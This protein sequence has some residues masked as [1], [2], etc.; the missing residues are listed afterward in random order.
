MIILDN[1]DLFIKEKLQKDQL[2]SKKAEDVFDIFLK[3]DFKMEEKNEKKV[4]TKDKQVKIPIMKRLL[5]TAASLVIVFG[6]ANVYATTNGYG[7]VFFMIK[8]LVTGEKTVVT[9]KSEILSDRDISISYEP[10]R[11]TENIRMQI[12]N[13]QVKDN[14]AKLIIAINEAKEEDSSIV[15]LKYKVYNSAN[16]LLCEQKS[17]KD[18]NNIEY[19]EELILDKFK[20]EDKILILEVNKA[21]NN[22]IAKITIDLQSRNITVE[23]EAEALKKV[24]EIELKKYLGVISE[25]NGEPKGDEGKIRFAQEIF[26]EIKGKSENKVDEINNMLESLG[27]EKVS[28]SF[29]QG[30]D[31][32]KIT[33][34]GTSYYEVING[35]DEWPYTVLD[36]S[37]ISFCDGLYTAIFTYIKM[38]EDGSFDADYSNVEKYEA[39]VYFRVNDDDKYSKFKIV[40]YEEDGNAQTAD[41]IIE[42][43]NEITDDQTIEINAEQILKD[44]YS[45]IE[46][47]MFS[48]HSYFKLDKENEIG[49]RKILNFEEKLSEDFTDN[50]KENFK[51]NRPMGVIEEN[52]EYYYADWGGDYPYVVLEKIENVET[53]SNKI[54]ADMVFKCFDIEDNSLPSK[55]AKIIV[56]KKD[57][58]WLVD[59]FNIKYVF[60]EFDENEK[61]EVNS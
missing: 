42:N 13:L 46:K 52:G 61:T 12:R 59:E 25:Y 34:D 4:E 1:K 7:N 28:D 40:K 22:K 47:V 38:H 60:R 10:I 11:L 8:Y 39:T 45:K 56:I 58:K 41:F 49:M 5:A 6:M 18:K 14:E 31:Y 26:N 17:Q 36:I 16:E 19:T 48:V 27:I 50:M 30:E 37:D 33:K 9:D 21:N 44:K 57:G 35:W 32:K 3:G 55:V 43:N 53:N 54:T 2:I 23:G 24:S 20:E 51:E 15:P 29:T